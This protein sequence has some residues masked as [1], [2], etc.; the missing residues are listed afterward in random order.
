M[1]EYTSGLHY[2][3]GAKMLRV[4]RPACERGSLCSCKSVQSECSFVTY[5]IVEKVVSA[6]CSVKGWGFVV[7]ANFAVGADH[8]ELI[9]YAKT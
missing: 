4:S 2:L 6:S 9:A 7:V 3:T 5:A 1:T 8:V